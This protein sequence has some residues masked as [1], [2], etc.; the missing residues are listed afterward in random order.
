[1]PDRPQL[2]NALRALRVNAGASLRQVA[3]RIGYSASSLSAAETGQSVPRWDLVE[4]VARHLG[5]DV[6]V[7]RRLHQAATSPQMAGG[8]LIETDRASG[9]AAATVAITLTIN[10]GGVTTVNLPGAGVWTSCTTATAAVN[11][12]EL[13][14][15]MLV[16]G[17]LHHLWMAVQDDDP[18]L[19]GCCKVC[20][21]PC[22]ALHQLLDTGQLDALM[23]IY[24]EHTGGEDGTWDAANGRVDRGLLERA[25]SVRLGCCGDDDGPIS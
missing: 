19:A 23:R 17:H 4:K 25:W 14:A 20:C 11:L 5:G 6:D 3:S 7:F 2:A 9:P 21:G 15:A 13:P 1:M 12:P 18:D 16:A 24:V 22:W 10:G 8:L